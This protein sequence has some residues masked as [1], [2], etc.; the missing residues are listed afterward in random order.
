VTQQFH[1][2]QLRPTAKATE[3]TPLAAAQD[4]PG[5]SLRGLRRSRSPA[6]LDATEHD[7]FTTEQVLAELR[8]AITYIASA[9]YLIEQG[10]D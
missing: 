8:G 7:S 2:R 1:Q 10:L 4:E 3:G 9:I 6:S 5:D